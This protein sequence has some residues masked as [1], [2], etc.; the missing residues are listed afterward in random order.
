MKPIKEVNSAIYSSGNSF[1]G[2]NSSHKD[3]NRLMTESKDYISKLAYKLAEVTTSILSTSKGRNKICSLI[4]YHAKLI[5]TS[6]INSNVPEVR[7]MLM[8]AMT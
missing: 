4:Q 7:E 1:A 5:F 8:Y 6:T 3:I 2:A